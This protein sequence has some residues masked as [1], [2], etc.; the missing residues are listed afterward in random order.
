MQPVRII[1]IYTLELFLF[2]KN[3]HLMDIQSYNMYTDNHC[4][5]SVA[6]L[7]NMHSVTVPLL[8]SWKP[9]S[10]YCKLHKLFGTMQHCHSA[11]V[12]CVCERV[13]EGGGEE[14]LYDASLFT[15]CSVN[16]L[17]L[18]SRRKFISQNL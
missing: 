12:C 17:Q 4:E 6:A 5:D 7:A 10:T 8:Q 15:G 14:M 9:F 13:G 3:F 2:N 11:A 16:L 1:S 18:G